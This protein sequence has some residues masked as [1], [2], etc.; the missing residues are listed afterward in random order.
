MLGD[1]VLEDHGCAARCTPCNERL[2][3]LKQSVGED[4]KCGGWQ[5]AVRIQDDSGMIFDVQVQTTE[6]TCDCTECSCS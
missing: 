4:E 1:E 5:I 3:L 6:D 2:V